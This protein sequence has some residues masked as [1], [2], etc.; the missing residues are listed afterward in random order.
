[1]DD[2]SIG[3]FTIKEKKL[4]D[5]KLG[6][7]IAIIAPKR[8]GKTSLIKGFFYYNWKKIRLPLVISSTA[9]TTL[10]FNNIVPDIFIHEEYSKDSFRS[11]MAEQS[12]VSKKIA[13]NYFG[14]DI[15]KDGVIVLDDI[16][17]TN[18]EWKK[19]KEFQKL[20]FQGRHLNVT[21]LLSVQHSLFIP[22]EYRDC[23]DYLIICKIK[24]KKSRKDIFDK[25]WNESLGDINLLNELFDECFSVNHRF[26]VFDF[27]GT[28]KS[29]SSVE[30]TVFWMK[31]HDPKTLL[32]KRFRVGLKKFW[33]LNK[34][35]YDPDWVFKVV[36]SSSNDVRK[37]LTRP[38]V[39]KRYNIKMISETDE[40][41]KNY[42]KKKS[43]YVKR[44][45]KN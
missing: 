8:S 6:T 9:S 10:D 11:F 15:I 14:K 36:G 28:G 35:Y 13:K 42:D 43:I 12:D 22:S 23:I 39:E 44:F 20:F 31:L 45:R 30:D 19:D 7:T 21:G 3:K 37:T 34:I 16:I 33:K 17:G 41:D 18:S 29:G 26:M 40:S 27:T 32:H 1:M 2:L 4:R 25:F 38:K 5:I 24:S